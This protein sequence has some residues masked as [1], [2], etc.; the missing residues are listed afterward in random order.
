MVRADISYD[1]EDFGMTAAELEDKYNG[2]GIGHPEYDFTKWHAN[3]GPQHEVPGYNGYWDW[4]AQSIA[5]DDDAIPGNDNEGNP[6]V[7]QA[8]E[9]E[10]V[11]L[12]NL[13]LFAAHLVAWHS[14]QIAELEHFLDIPAGTEFTV[15]IDGDEKVV[16][17]DGDVLAAFRGGLATALTKLGTLPF[18]AVSAEDVQGMVDVVTQVSTTDG[19]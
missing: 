13:D 7:T 18:T 14:R 3:P 1:Y 17:L 5:K 11:M 16:I 2:N 15:N 19:S 9:Q 12:N 6:I 8:A 10:I 4:V